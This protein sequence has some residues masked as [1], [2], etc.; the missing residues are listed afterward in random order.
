MQVIIPWNDLFPQYMVEA[1]TPAGDLTV[2][3]DDSH[4]VI[5][6][7]LPPGVDEGDVEIT[8]CPC[9]R[10]GLPVAGCGPTLIKARIERPQPTVENTVPEKSPTEHEVAQDER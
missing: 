1:H 4:R 5:E 10:N 2:M 9:D 7:N 8:G 3:A 6:V